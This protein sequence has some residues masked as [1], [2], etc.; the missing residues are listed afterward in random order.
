MAALRQR[1][2][3]ADWVRWRAVIVPGRSLLLLCAS[4]H[5]AEAGPRHCVQQSP[6]LSSC[7]SA[8]NLTMAGQGCAVG[9][10]L[11]GGLLRRPGAAQVMTAK[12]VR[13]RKAV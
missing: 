10:K 7:H 12:P 1:S 4:G 3:R 9:D 8:N 6:A 11:V 2:S 13:T 5:T